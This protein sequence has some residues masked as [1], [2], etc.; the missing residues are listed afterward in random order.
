MSLGSFYMWLCPQTVQVTSSRP[1]R[2]FQRLE[3]S[4]CTQISP[5]LTLLVSTFDVRCGLRWTRLGPHSPCG[6][7][8]CLAR[9]PQP[10][11]RHER[12][13][14][15]PYSRCMPMVLQWSQGGGRFLMGEEMHRLARACSG[16]ELISLNVLIKWF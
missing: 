9:P 8:V 12:F 4:L 13:P 5:P 1:S 15:G 10:K 14:L 11:A 16:Y 3:M 7:Y 2:L 6:E